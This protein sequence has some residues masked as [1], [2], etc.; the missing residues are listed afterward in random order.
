MT[1]NRRAKQPSSTRAELEK[2]LGDLEPVRELMEEVR[3]YPVE[4]LQQ[5]CALHQRT[6]GPVAD[7]TLS[8]A[9]YLGDV[10]LRALLMGGLIEQMDPGHHA[11]YA[12]LPTKKG[13]KL[14]QGLEAKE[15]KTVAKVKKAKS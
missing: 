5:V 1:T 12:Y 6:G 3:R 2:L 10:A 9:P 13:L 15:S 8:L 4:L 7:H 11:M 14:C